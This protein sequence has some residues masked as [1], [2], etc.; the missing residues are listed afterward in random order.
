MIGASS[1]SG[2]KVQRS[3]PGAYKSANPYLAYEW[4]ACYSR[5][6]GNPFIKESPGAVRS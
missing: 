5:Y 1:L 4:T 3:Q 2:L 6:R